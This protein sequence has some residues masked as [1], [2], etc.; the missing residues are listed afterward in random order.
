MRFE[1]FIVSL[2]IVIGGIIVGAFYKTDTA[3][4]KQADKVDYATQSAVYSPLAFTWSREEPEVIDLTALVESETT[5]T[6]KTT[7]IAQRKI[8]QTVVKKENAAKPIIKNEIV[9]E[10]VTE[11]VKTDEKTNVPTVQKP[12]IPTVTP[13][14]TGN[15]PEANGNDQNENVTEN[16][17]TTPPIMG[18]AFDFQGIQDTLDKQQTGTNPMVAPTPETSTEPTTPVETPT[19]TV[20]PTSTPKPTTPPKPIETEKPTSSLFD[21]IYATGLKYLGTPYEFGAK[22]GQTATFDCSSF[23]QYIFGQHGVKLPRSS[24]QQATAGT[25]V[26]F[27]N[28]Q[29]G[30]LLIFD[31]TSREGID[32]VGMYIGDGK[33]LHSNTS[34]GGVHVKEL[35][36]FWKDSIVTVRRV[37]K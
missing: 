22:A 26:S 1:K 6:E 10:N 35:T 34:G 16:V 4:G 8:Y 33:M 5:E 23:M 21:K 29:K 31:V 37:L 13:N 19:P 11:N 15:V 20:K 12:T 36:T 2:I 27:A 3:G 24:K 28:V 17:P 25:Q 9:T 7:P 14:V 18:N 30:D 32:H